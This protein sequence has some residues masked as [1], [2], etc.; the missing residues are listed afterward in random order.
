LTLVVFLM[1]KF[2]SKKCTP[3]QPTAKMFSRSAIIK[4]PCASFLFSLVGEFELKQQE[5]KVAAAYF[6][7]APPLN[8]LSEAGGAPQPPNSLADIL[9][10]LPPMPEGWKPGDTIPGLGV[11]SVPAPSVT[12]AAPIKKAPKAT[13]S[14]PTVEGPLSAVFDFS[15]N[16]DMEMEFGASESE[17][18]TSEDD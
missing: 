13:P 3:N 17:D 18:E 7:A 15:L 1:F 9:S 2:F 11:P 10:N 4:S 5:G 12:A 6:A 8:A 14:A 16:P